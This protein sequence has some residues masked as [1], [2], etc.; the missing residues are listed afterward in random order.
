MFRRSSSV[1]GGLTLGIGETYSVTHCL[2]YI[3]VLVILL[4][5][6]EAGLASSGKNSFFS[7]FGISP[8]TVEFLSFFFLTFSYTSYSSMV[9]A[10][11]ETS[12]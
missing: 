6:N 11:F 2:G 9:G 5:M 8:G 1:S 7:F 10:S 4:N 12:G 3:P